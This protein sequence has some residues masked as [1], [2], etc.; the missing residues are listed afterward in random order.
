MDEKPKPHDDIKP[1]L[2]ADDECTIIH[3]LSS[4]VQ[5]LLSPVVSLPDAIFSLLEDSEVLF[6]GLLA[7]IVTVFRVSDTIA[8][9]VTTQKSAVRESRT[10][11]YLEE[12]LPDF[13]APRSHGLIQLGRYYLLFMTFMGSQNLKE[14]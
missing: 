12:H 3:G 9:K 7:S 2:S 10:L 6:T 8:L 13:P 4:E 5:T 11:H 14:V 1:H